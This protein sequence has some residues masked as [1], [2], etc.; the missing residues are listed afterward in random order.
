MNFTFF[1]RNKIGNN[2]LYK[3]D[4]QIQFLN[5]GLQNEI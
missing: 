4:N 5:N 3:I 1:A 2:Y